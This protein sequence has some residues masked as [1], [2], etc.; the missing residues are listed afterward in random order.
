MWVPATCKSQAEGIQWRL[1]CP[2]S[3]KGGSDESSLAIDELWA[4]YEQSIAQARDP[5]VKSCEVVVASAVR[6][7][8]LGVSKALN[9]ELKA[10]ADKW[11]LPR[12]KAFALAVASQKKKVAAA[13]T[14]LLRDYTKAGAALTKKG[15]TTQTDAL[16]AGEESVLARVEVAGKRTANQDRRKSLAEQYWLCVRLCFPIAAIHWDPGIPITGHITIA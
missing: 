7:G 15:G 16:R 12:D 3:Q 1:F 13:N 11:T 6:K 14:T 4:G 10:F 9:A 5:F 8:E 2:Q